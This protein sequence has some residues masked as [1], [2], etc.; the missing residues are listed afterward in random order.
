M[1]ARRTI[2]IVSL[3]AI[4]AFLALFIFLS[5]LSA[6]GPGGGP[7]GG[8]APGGGGGG[9][10][11]GLSYSETHADA[12]LEKTYPEYLA[13]RPPVPIPQALL[14]DDKGQPM[15]RTDSAWNEYEM[16]YAKTAETAEVKAAS[17]PGR[18][19]K[20][21][22]QQM[23][24]QL[25]VIKKEN[26][27][28]IRA[29]GAAAGAFTFEVGYPQYDSTAVTPA[30]TTVRVGVIMRVKKSLSQNY[31]STIY[32]LLKPYDNYG[33]GRVPFTFVTYQGGYYR[34]QSLMLH[35]TSV[36]VWNALWAT[37]TVALVL[38][39]VKGGVIVAAN[40]SA[41]F[42]LNAPTL[43]AYPPEIR[44]TPAFAYLMPEADR[45]FNGGKMNLDY[46]RGWYYEFAFSLNMEDL[47]RLDHA[48]AGIVMPPSKMMLESVAQAKYAQ[49][50][51]PMLQ[52]K[53]SA[54]MATQVQGFGMPKATPGASASVKPA[55]EETASGVP[56][57]A[58][59]A[60]T[61]AMGGGYNALPMP[62]TA[63]G[64]I[65]L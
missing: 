1:G 41:G 35:P 26:V 21:L 4:A 10:G 23:Q 42:N 8:G 37:P 18:V 16:L 17:A 46:T 59:S 32:R 60:A 34:P 14:V 24:L 27:A 43:I 49:D 39:D 28:M 11:G 45:L 19:G 44:R 5:S 63:V 12:L 56:P 25:A 62:A 7:P 51:M 64:G 2:F 31:G 13:G 52:P 55:G 29:M 15:K 9:G 30:G 40:Q 58:K 57:A 61:G 50:I 48:A 65:P 47:A 3:V 36:A 53:L 6:Q 33:P 20:V 38:K 22:T 54:W